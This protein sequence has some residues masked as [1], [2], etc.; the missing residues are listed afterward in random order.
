MPTIPDPSRLVVH[1]HPVLHH[2]L[3]V[4]RNPDTQ[5]P[6]FRARL[7][8]IAALMTFNATKHLPVRE[9]S[10]WT[11]LEETRCRVLAA[12]VTVV[13]ILRA[14]LAMAD[15]VL[16]VFPEARIGHLGLAR[17]E[18]TL[19]P[20]AYLD[21]LPRDIDAGPVLAVDPMLATGGSAIAA[22]RTLRAAGAKH[23]VFVCLVAAPEGVVNL[24]NAD[25][26]VIIH[27]AALDR[28]LNE[29][30]YIL[31]GLGDAGDRAFGTI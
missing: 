19:Q 9:V 1:D 25:P 20:V 14:G 7:S 21:R 23:V 31:P 15:G 30:G 10:M 4:L 6:A 29:K 3:A 27:V 16:T 5:P 22:L 28:Q 2:K 18:E 24:Q 11:P 17:D 26:D 13:P 12:P 8:E